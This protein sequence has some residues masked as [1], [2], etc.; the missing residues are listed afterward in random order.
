MIKFIIITLLTFCATT[1]NAQ[2][3]IGKQSITNKSISLEFGS[4]DRGIILPYV[5]SAEAVQNK[6]VV[7]GTLV[8]DT[9]DK[10]VKLRAN[11]NWVDLSKSDEGIVDVNIQDNKI[12]KDDAKV[13]I[14]KNGSS[15]NTPGILVLSDTDKAMV[16]PKVDSPHLN[17]VNPSAGMLVYDTKSR[18]LAV[19]NG[20]VWTFWQ[21]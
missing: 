15:N 8:F 12:E 11:N 17:I 13:I 5:T 10:K 16:L 1:I 19:F 14:G 4:G 21:P 18:Q 6:G 20:K 7:D 2:V 3:A 9:T